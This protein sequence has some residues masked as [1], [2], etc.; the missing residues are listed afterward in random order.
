[1]ASDW[2][3]GDLA[4]MM[5]EVGYELEYASPNLCPDSGGSGHAVEVLMGGMPVGR[6]VHDSAS[7]RW[8]F[9]AGEPNLPYV[10][11]VPRR[12][13][14]PPKDEWPPRAIRSVAFLAACRAWPHA[15]AD[16][17]GDWYGPLRVSASD[18]QRD[19]DTHEHVEA[20]VTQI[21]LP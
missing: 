12:T 7:G 10:T 21:A 19:V 20:F 1:M 15:Y 11:A 17:G 2:C 8:R 9:E 18:A 16:D 4:T 13:E 5:A 6:A 14:Q 3:L